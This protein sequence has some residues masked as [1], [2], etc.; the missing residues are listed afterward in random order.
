MADLSVNYA[1]LRLKNP[2][3]C[4][5]GPL[6]DTVERCRVAAKHHFAAIVLKSIMHRGAGELRYK[7]AVPRFKVVDRLRPYEKWTPDKGIDNMTVI[8][9]GEAGSVWTEEEYG[10]FVD[11]V[12]QA[13]GDE[14]KVAA[15]LM[16]PRN[17][18][19][20]Q[21][22]FELFSNSKA[23]FIEIDFG[24]SRYYKKLNDAIEIIKLA[25]R[26]LSIPITVKMYPFLTDPIEIAVLFQ[27]AGVDGL[28]MFDAAAGLDFDINGMKLPF[29]NT[30]SFIA[31]GVILP[32]TN[33]C[34]AGARLNNIKASLSASFGVWQWQDVIKCIMSGANAVQLCRRIMVRGYKEAD[35]FLVKINDWLDQNG[36]NSIE[37]LSGSILD[38]LL[39][40]ARQIPREEPIERG[41]IPSLKAVVDKD[42]CKGCTDLCSR[43]CMYFAHN[44]IAGKADVD[45]SKCGGCGM[46]E[47]ICPY[48]AISL[49]PRV[50]T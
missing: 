3:I 4:A 36:H 2:L 1:G 38:K 23:D 17:I 27:E 13:V 45:E 37:E 32:Y 40:D 20:Y 50:I 29:Y 43:V 21:E 48:D 39:I 31:P 33:L 47:G 8:A 14:V 30:W 26:T 11:Q 49:L 15:S 9:A 22:Y 12:K 16:G 5:S 25:K 10:R 6:T 44:P 18:R 41:G 7:H 34:I 46:C 28:T 24:Y 19:G 35:T 42:K